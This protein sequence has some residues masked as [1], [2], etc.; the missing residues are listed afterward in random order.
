M[1]RL[2]LL[3]Q[4]HALNMLRN[5]SF[6]RG[7]AHWWGSYLRHA[8]LKGSQGVGTINAP[9]YG[10]ELY[11]AAVTSYP[12]TVPPGASQ[13][14]DRPD[15]F[16][17]PSRRT[18]SGLLFI[19]YSETQAVLQVSNGLTALDG[20]ILH[21][22]ASPV[23]ELT[24]DNIFQ[25]P[26]VHLDTDT[27]RVDIT[28]GSVIPL[29]DGRRSASSGLY[30]VGELLTNRDGSAVDSAYDFSIATPNVHEYSYHG[31]RV[32]PLSGGRYA[33][34]LTE[35]TN[36]VQGAQVVMVGSVVTV[37]IQ[38][39][40]AIAKG[41]DREQDGYAPAAGIAV[42][43]VFTMSA[44]SLRSG[45]VTTIALTASEV[46]LTLSPLMNHGQEIV[47][48][49]SADINPTSWAI[50]ITSTATVIRT[51][52]LYAYDFTLG[53]TYRTS[54][55]FAAPAS[56]DM[57]FRVLDGDTIEGVGRVSTTVPRVVDK[58]KVVN[59]AADDVTADGEWHRR[60]E[61]HFREAKH[62]IDG[63]LAL[64]IAPPIGKFDD[65][66]SALGDL[67]PSVS[68][69]FFTDSS[70]IGHADPQAPVGY[71]EPHFR[72]II[73]VDP[74]DL[75]PSDW[76]SGTKEFV[77]H[78]FGD[79][80][81]LALS[82]SW[83]LPLLQVPS[84]TANAAVLDVPGISFAATL[85]LFV[86]WDET[87]FGAFPS[88]GPENQAWSNGQTSWGMSTKGLFTSGSR[89][90]ITDLYLTHGDLAQRLEKIDDAAL[91][92]SGPLTDQ[93]SID[94]LRHG[95]DL[96]D[97]VIPPG[98]VILYAGGGT[99]P[100]GF[101][102]VEGFQS[103][104]LAGVGEP[105]PT[106]AMTAVYDTALDRTTFTWDGV[107]FPL[108]DAAGAVIPIPELQAPVAAE[109]PGWPGQYEAIA[110][111]PVQQ[112][113]QP[114]MTIRIPDFAMDPAVLND[115]LFT[116]PSSAVFTA[117]DYRAPLEERDRSHLVTNVTSVLGAVDGTYASGLPT[118]PS[119]TAGGQGQGSILYPFTIADTELMAGDADVPPLGPG[120][121]SQDEVFSGGSAQ[122]NQIVKFNFVGGVAV[123][124]SVDSLPP[125]VGFAPAVGDVY[126]MHW[127][128]TSS[129]ST[130]L[131]WFLTRLTAI[132]TVPG[133]VIPGGT[134]TGPKGPDVTQYTLVR[135]DGRPIQIT[136]Q[137]AATL[138][139]YFSQFSEPNPFKEGV[140]V[141]PGH[142]V[143]RPAKLLGAGQQIQNVETGEIDPQEVLINQVFVTTPAGTQLQWTV[144]RIEATLKVDVQG[145]AHIA[146][147]V[148]ELQA[149][150][151]GY[152]RYDDPE[153]SLDYGAGGHNHLVS[154]EI[155]AT[156]GLVPRID[157]TG[158]L[159]A[160]PYENVA[161]NHDHGY[162]STFRFPLPQFRWFTACQKL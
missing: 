154:S 129:P 101:K 146:D 153:D 21:G 31:L 159:A 161:Q 35:S 55:G 10:L 72:I 48:P 39:P 19:P 109:V 36:T 41:L 84:F 24:Y 125:P 149:E 38:I 123:S 75:P 65:Y 47:A 152:L 11:R 3:N 157:D 28:P 78:P 141:Y 56:S 69:L 103:V 76:T 63:R 142:V 16:T 12:D 116:D 1:T 7:T 158:A 30:R 122:T 100:P 98:T 156:A 145:H 18:V 97:H 66:P 62:P 83:I 4:R 151:T 118:A 67:E 26:F 148:T 82:F 29:T 132:Q 115:P 68:W 22:L 144:R 27:E 104:D 54:D 45:V 6:T 5:G 34:I 139:P 85:T 57:T 43:D 117:A 99:C 91:P 79:L 89:S 143:L 105:L 2:D 120:F 60:L 106:A 150:A 140:W 80:A 124:I 77:M 155:E 108:L 32:S 40:Q 52:P 136:Q 17:Y 25:H 94:P 90:M 70:D 9:E 14:L 64:T 13:W 42:G 127:V 87:A 111:V 88:T 50:Y 33:P 137:Q 160:T 73:P 86:T 8:R 133:H 130:I 128:R 44:P 96:L 126:F 112:R 93:V 162:L 138:Y 59:F 37:T 121:S 46:T 74:L 113:V 135:Y 81:Q 15:L 58:T 23:N 20:V 114:G 61:R 119:G 71:D 53:L 92:A 107:E 147:N 95:V 134:S 102:R 110:F 131:G 51:L 49:F